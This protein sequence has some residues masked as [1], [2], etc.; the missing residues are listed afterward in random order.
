MFLRRYTLNP[1]L[2]VRVV[3][4]VDDVPTHLPK[5][6]ALQQDAVEEAEG[7]EQLFVG[8]RSGAAVELGVGHQLVQTL[9]VGFHTLKTNGFKTRLREQNL[10]RDFTSFDF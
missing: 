4:A 5:L 9:H 7:E 1:D 3:E 6:L 8:R 2:K 10:T